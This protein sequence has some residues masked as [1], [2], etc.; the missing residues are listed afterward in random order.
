MEM[1]PQGDSAHLADH[2]VA[3][4]ASDDHYYTV[5]D[6][7]ALDAAVEHND[8]AASSDQGDVDDVYV[9]VDGFDTEDSAASVSVHGVSRQ[10]AGVIPMYDLESNEEGYYTV[11]RGSTPPAVFPRR[12]SSVQYAVASPLGGD[13]SSPHDD[14]DGDVWGAGARPVPRLSASVVG[15]TLLS[16]PRIHS[17]APTQ[18]RG[19][20]SFTLDDDN[21][22][23]ESDM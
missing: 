14:T 23:V 18:R 21:D 11:R 3:A 1:A 15:R 8:D 2:V 10:S 20:P 7:I 22:V 13:H 9:P 4:S 16:T 6:P 12:R 5:I 17:D 19:P